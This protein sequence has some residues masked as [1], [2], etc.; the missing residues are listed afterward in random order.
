[1]NNNPSPDSDLEPAKPFQ[2]WKPRTPGTRLRRHGGKRSRPETPLLKWKIHDDPLEDDQKSSVAGSRRRTCR[3]AK[4]QAEVAVSAR[5]LAAGLLRLHLPETA[6]GD[7][8][9]GLEHKV[10]NLGY[11]SYTLGL[12]LT[13]SQKLVFAVR[14]FLCLYTLLSMTLVNLGSQTF[15][16][17]FFSFFL[18]FEIPSF[19]SFPCE[20]CCILHVFVVFDLNVILQLHATRLLHLLYC[21]PPLTEEKELIVYCWGLFIFI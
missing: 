3:S 8:R 15:T 4:K 1:M 7:G 13:Q 20:G 9:K 5:R 12:G 10:G 11:S 6:T 2:R 19:S 16:L 17:L 21:R 14:V 18:L